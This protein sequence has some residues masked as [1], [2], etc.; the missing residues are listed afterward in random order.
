MQHEN[1]EMSL[2]GLLKCRQ[3][4]VHASLVTLSVMVFK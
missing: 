1:V 3:Y 2:F 4:D